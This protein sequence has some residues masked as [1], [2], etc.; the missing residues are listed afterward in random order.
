M[1][2]SRYSA[3]SVSLARSRK[4]SIASRIRLF[5]LAIRLPNFLFQYV[6]VRGFSSG[7]RRS[8]LRCIVTDT[9]LIASATPL[10]TSV[11]FTH[12]SLTLPCTR[13]L[14]RSRSMLAMW[15]FL[16]MS[17]YPTTASTGNPGTTMNSISTSCAFT[18]PLHSG[19]LVS[20]FTRTATVSAPLTDPTPTNGGASPSP[21][22]LPRGTILGWI[23]LASAIVSRPITVS[24]RPTIA[25]AH[26]TE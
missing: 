12:T 14:F 9:A 6:C 24:L 2:R 11:A 10:S 22:T 23:K 21:M 15:S 25:V 18:I 3:H 7:M 5:A 1:Y 4:S 16:F 8:P 13:N 17:L 26:N 20:T 19:S